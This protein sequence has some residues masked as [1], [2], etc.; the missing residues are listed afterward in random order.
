MY[1]IHFPPGAG[2]IIL[3]YPDS[4]GM[5]PWNQHQIAHPNRLTVLSSSPPGPRLRLMLAHPPH[6]CG[7]TR[8]PELLKGLQ[9]ASLSSASPIQQQS[10]LAIFAGKSLLAKARTRV[11]SAALS[12]WGAPRL[13]FDH[14]PLPLPCATAMCQRCHALLGMLIL[15]GECHVKVCQGCLAPHNWVKWILDRQK[16]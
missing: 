16:R 4:R 5:W 14:V 7:L 8:K 3:A 10:L 9:E 1:P 15:K 13:R 6:L 2:Y 11:S 12:K